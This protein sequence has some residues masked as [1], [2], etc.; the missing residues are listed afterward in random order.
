MG[1][2]FRRSGRIPNWWVT[3]QICEFI[4]MVGVAGVIGRLA[5]EGV[6]PIWL[7]ALGVGTIAAVFVLNRQLKRRYLFPED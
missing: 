5:T 6:D 7:W 3:L 4:G 2:R 1:R